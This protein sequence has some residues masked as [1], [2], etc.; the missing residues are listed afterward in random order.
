MMHELATVAPYFV[1][2]IGCETFVSSLDHVALVPH[3]APG[4]VAVVT[5]GDE[6]RRVVAG[7]RALP[8]ADVAG[9]RAAFERFATT[10]GVDLKSLD[11]GRALAL[12]SSGYAPQRI[13]DAALDEDGDMLLLQWGV[14]DWGEGPSFEYGLTRQL[15]CQHDADDDAIWQLGLT[16][17]D[18]PSPSVAAVGRG[19]RWCGT[20]LEL[21]E[22]Q[23]FALTAPAT[24]AVV[25]VTPKRVALRFEISG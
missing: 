15:V 22:F 20:P 6:M 9:A 13:G 21:V 2:P 23:R 25:G 1:M 18:R 11:A 3:E 14:Y 24:S 4:P 7:E 5:T 17:H 16:L 12:M 19:N 8:P 10:W